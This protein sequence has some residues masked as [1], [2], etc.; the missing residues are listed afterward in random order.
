MEYN[1]VLSYTVEEWK[2]QLAEGEWIPCKTGGFGKTSHA[3]GWWYRKYSEWHAVDGTEYYQIYRPDTDMDYIHLGY[4]DTTVFKLLNVGY[5][6][7]QEF[8]NKPRARKRPY[9]EVYNNNLEAD[10]PKKANFVDL[11]VSEQQVVED[12]ERRE[13][14]AT[15]KKAEKKAE[16]HRAKKH[17]EDLSKCKDKLEANIKKMLS[18]AELEICVCYMWYVVV[19]WYNYMGL[20]MFYVV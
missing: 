15:T 3:Y 4:P 12:K 5:D 2:K 7:L 1:G 11:R 17:L 18:K 10:L 16:K 19:M 14:K 8:N 6:A 13:A 20:F 9:K